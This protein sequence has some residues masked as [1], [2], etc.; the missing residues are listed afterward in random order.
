[1]QRE[2]GRIENA[3]WKGTETNEE[4]WERGKLNPLMGVKAKGN[5]T[6]TR[7]MWWEEEYQRGRR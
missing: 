7:R 2:E 3:T 6:T 1:M 4:A 5:V